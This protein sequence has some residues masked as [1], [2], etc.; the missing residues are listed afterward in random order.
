MKQILSGD[1]NLCKELQNCIKSQV[2]TNIFKAN[3]K[4]EVNKK[5]TWC[6]DGEEGPKGN[7]EVENLKGHLEIYVPK[8][9][10]KKGKK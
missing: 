4:I 2:P 3:S 1:L 8:N 10:I 9:K 7:I 6:V 5:A